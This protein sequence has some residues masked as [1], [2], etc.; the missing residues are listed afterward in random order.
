MADTHIT[1]ERRRAF[2][3]LTI[4]QYQNFVC[5]PV[6]ATATPRLPSLPST[7]VRE[8]SGEDE[9][10]VTPMF[11][12]IHPSMKLTDHDGREA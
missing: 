3:A 12:S 11:V 7:S 9:Y 8:E 2:D 10:Q 5:F 4:G 1:D 6:P